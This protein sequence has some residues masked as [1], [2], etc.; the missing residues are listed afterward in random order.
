MC[1]ND[2][3][4]TFAISIMSLSLS[5]QI[6]IVCAFLICCTS[7]FFFIPHA[8]TFKIKCFQFHIIFLALS[9]KISI[10]RFTCLNIKIRYHT[11]SLSSDFLTRSC[12]CIPHLRHKFC[13]FFTPHAPTFK[14]KFSQFQVKDCSFLF[15]S[16]VST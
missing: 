14:I 10:F 11:S 3:S 15:D 12:V 1:L 6:S 2:L 13:F 7:L 16:H 8:R 5:F 9:F 4:H